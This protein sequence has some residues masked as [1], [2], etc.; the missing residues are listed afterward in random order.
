MDRSHRGA[1]ALSLALSGCTATVAPPLGWS[2]RAG[3][4]FL[5]DQ[6]AREPWHQL[7]W[8]APTTDDPA[9]FQDAN[10]FR[11]QTRWR[12]TVVTAGWVPEPEHSL[13]FLA[14]TDSGWSPISIIRVLPECL[15]ELCDS[16]NSLDYESYLI[17][18]AD[19]DRLVAVYERL[20]DGERSWVDGDRGVSWSA[21]GTLPL[22][23]APVPTLP[24]GMRDEERQWRLEEGSE[25]S[26][27]PEAD[28][29]R[30]EWSIPVAGGAAEAL[31][32]EGQAWFRALTLPQRTVE[33][34]DFVEEIDAEA[35]PTGA[36]R[37]AW[38]AAVAAEAH[39]APMR[40]FDLTPEPAE[41]PVWAG[42]VWPV[43]DGAPILGFQARSTWSVEVN[44]GAASERALVE[45][46]KTASSGEDSLS[47]NADFLEKY[48]ALYER[49][50]LGYAAV[51]AELE[52]GAWR[53]IGASL[54][55]ADGAVL[56]VADLSPFDKLCFARWLAREPDPFEACIWELTH[57]VDSNSD[58]DHSA[59]WAAAAVLRSEPVED[60]VVG[61]RGGAVSFSASDQK[62]LWSEA[63]ERTLAVSFGGRWSGEGSDSF[64]LAPP[65]FHALL[66][67]LAE[68]RIESLILDLDPTVGVRQLP[69]ARAE[70][71]WVET[72]PS[73][74]THLNANTGTVEE[75][76]N[77]VGLSE[78]DATALVGWRHRHGPVAFVSDW[79]GVVSSG[80]LRKLE[81][82]GAA[83]TSGEE[84]TFSVTATVD[85]A[86]DLVSGSH[87]DVAE[88]E[89]IRRAYRYT[90]VT[91][92]LGRWV[93]GAWDNPADH[94]DFAWVARWS[95]RSDAH[96]AWANPFVTVAELE[97]WWGE[98]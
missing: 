27:V 91:D 61:P 76:R 6:S 81:Q 35:V 24:W 8:T 59:G 10:S 1:F 5:L 79:T 70:W 89:R 43:R 20:G 71:T 11:F 97:R 23:W 84:R 95:P 67:E 52:S 2:W 83:N 15:E 34:V 60:V 44:A 46:A 96:G 74:M 18:Q 37:T 41:R 17:L 9:G 58:A 69:V 39:G 63:Y 65:L 26:S 68:Q 16:G 33:R 21:L 90:L 45:T 54:H 49:I 77:F 3:D 57:H 88:P 93:R 48:Q 92:H 4:T 82:R 56:P 62:A 19:R 47:T 32:D 22:A 64:D 78:R 13:R 36:S 53:R 29:I 42:P 30:I 31:R 50:R 55:H 86:S 14:N 73:A 25:I 72:T 87:V 28:G 85:F 98:E 51:E 66:Q 94:P 75:L 12:A 40:F 7:G 80:A 38:E